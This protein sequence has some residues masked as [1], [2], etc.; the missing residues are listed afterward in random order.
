MTITAR[1]RDH[2]DVGVD[3]VILR[4]RIADLEHPGRS[5][6]F[7][8]QMMPVLSATPER[9]AVR[10]PDEFILVA[11]PVSRAVPSRVRE[12]C[13]CCNR[14]SVRVIIRIED[15]RVGDA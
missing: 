5:C 12:A 1:S 10:D 9:G 14:D 6:R 11:V 8:D 2:A 15:Y 7:V 13:R 3:A 4:I